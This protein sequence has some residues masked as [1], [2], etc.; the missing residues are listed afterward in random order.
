[1]GGEEREE[2]GKGKR[3]HKA[4]KLNTTYHTKITPHI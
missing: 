3:G 1:M 2:E 4:T